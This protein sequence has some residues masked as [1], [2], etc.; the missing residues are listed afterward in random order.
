MNAVN[1]VNVKDKYCIHGCLLANRQMAIRIFY[2]TLCMKNNIE[3]T[4]GK[5]LPI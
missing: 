4:I 2:G 1:S 3:E 5:Y